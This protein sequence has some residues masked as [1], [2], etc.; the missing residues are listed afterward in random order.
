MT[1]HVG[2]KARVVFCLILCGICFMAVGLVDFKYFNFGAPITCIGICMN[3]LITKKE[4][5]NQR[6]I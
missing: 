2:W 5:V 3:R 4:N 6:H 1:H